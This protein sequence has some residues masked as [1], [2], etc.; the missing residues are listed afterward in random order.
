MTQ[1]VYVGGYSAPDRHGRGDGINVYRV[2]SPMGPWTH[3]Q[4]VPS[5]D[6][7]S[8]LRVGRD[9]HAL[10]AVH[11]GRT[12]ISSY[13]I[14]PETGLLEF[15]NRQESGGTNP[16]DL[17]FDASGRHAVVAHYI[18]GTVGVLPI[19]VDGTLGAVAQSI[20]LRGTPGPSK[21]D[22]PG[23][24]PH[25]VT[26]DATGRFLLVPDK[27]LDRIFV[28]EFKDGT[29]VPAP[30]AS[31][32][33]VPGSGPRHAAFHPRLP[34]LYVVCELSSTVEVF[35][36]DVTN[37]GLQSMQS[38]SALPAGATGLASEIAVSASGICVYSSNR[39]HDSIARF[40]VDQESG[41]LS[42]ED[43]TLTGGK[44]PRAFAID[45]TGTVLHVANQTT[46]TIMSFPIDP[47]DG[48][49]SAGSLS[50]KIGTPTAIC[51]GAKL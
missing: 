42:L 45:P 26:P 38:I 29:L 11:A 46:D 39:G 4:H 28:F 49:L 34:M 32:A 22:Q 40:S 25:G 10:F 13:G 31:A 30:M 18:S 23:S 21:A 17:G 36:W 2:D 19:A 43:C 33:T 8:F 27:G 14:A 24:L 50:L 48:S 16:V 35:R 15:R 1:I 3:L 7:P 47:T 5:L 41:L 37:G 12:Y 20:P 44:E 51:F 9:G 6:N